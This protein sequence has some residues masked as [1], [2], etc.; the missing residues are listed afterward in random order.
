M[1]VVGIKRYTHFHN[2]CCGIAIK[3]QIMLKKP[4][5]EVVYKFATCSELMS[6]KKN[7]RLSFALTLKWSMMHIS[8][9]EFWLSLPQ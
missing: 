3:A 1:Q 4:S 5:N 6:L 8:G 2:N 7:A 9:V